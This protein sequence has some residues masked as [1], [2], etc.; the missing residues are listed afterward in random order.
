[1]NCMREFWECKR[2]YGR[3]FGEAILFIYLINHQ[4]HTLGG[5]WEKG[6]AFE[7]VLMRMVRLGLFSCIRESKKVE[8]TTMRPYMH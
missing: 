7:V 5:Y 8:A 1:M 2:T 4:W 3:K 6:L